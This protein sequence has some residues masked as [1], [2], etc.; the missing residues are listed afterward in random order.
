MLIPC[1]I[2]Y[3]LYLKFQLSPLEKII[4]MK[5]LLIM[6]IMIHQTLIMLLCFDNDLKHDLDDINK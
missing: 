2:R 1:A 5:N 3:Q 4:Y 6:S